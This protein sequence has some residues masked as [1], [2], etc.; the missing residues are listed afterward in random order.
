MESSEP[1][2][3]VS[4]LAKKRFA[5]EDEIAGTDSRAS[6]LPAL[7]G[8]PS[9]GRR[10]KLSSGHCHGLNKIARAQLTAAPFFQQETLSLNCNPDRRQQSINSSSY[11]SQLIGL[12]T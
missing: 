11:L 12:K 2:I 7:V 1:C 3:S 5:A 10:I 6:K 9:G 8:S 4:T